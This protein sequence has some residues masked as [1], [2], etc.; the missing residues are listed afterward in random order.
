MLKSQ[1][2]A[3]K[4]R[5]KDIWNLCLKFKHYFRPRFYITEIQMSNTYQMFLLIINYYKLMF[6]I[7]HLISHS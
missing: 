2:L 5:E 4:I 3:N 6:A 1:V 7:F